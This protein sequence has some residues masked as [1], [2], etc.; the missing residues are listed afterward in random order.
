MIPLMGKKK[1]IKNYTI[2]PDYDPFGAV[3]NDI[4]LVTLD[5]ELEFDDNVQA[6]EFNDENL[7]AGTKCTASGWGVLEAS[8]IKLIQISE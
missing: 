1:T 3:H 6:I 8:S 4:C 5:Y 2:H 7:I